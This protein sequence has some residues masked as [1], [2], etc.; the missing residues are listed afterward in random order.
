MALFM[1]LL[2]DARFALVDR[3]RWDPL[4]GYLWKKVS[5]TAL[6]LVTP[7]C[8]TPPV[9]VQLP[10][11]VQIMCRIVIGDVVRESKSKAMADRRHGSQERKKPLWC[12]LS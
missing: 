1:P 7:W 5:L 3:Q 8:R 2:K 6:D 9:M 11:L 10:V 12:G 4:I